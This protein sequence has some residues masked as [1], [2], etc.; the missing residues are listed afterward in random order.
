MPE[1]IVQEIR[2]AG[3]KNFRKDLWNSY[4]GVIHRGK[5]V[6]DEVRANEENLSYR[7][8]SLEG[9]LSIAVVSETWRNGNKGDIRIND[10]QCSVNIRGV[11]IVIYDTVT[12]HVVDSV[13]YDS[14]ESGEGTFKPSL[15]SKF[16]ELTF[17][18]VKSNVWYTV[19]KH[20]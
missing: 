8:E 13:G 14:H 6:F 17:P 11:N 19:T 16:F 10:V 3:F 5:V 18:L 7:Y 12:R 15:V 9:N 20:S 2:D 1:S 4:I